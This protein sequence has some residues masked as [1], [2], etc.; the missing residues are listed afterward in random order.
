MRKKITADGGGL[1]FNS[2]KVRFDLLA[3]DA[4]KELAWVMTDACTRK[5]NPYPE[6]TEYSAFLW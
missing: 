4:M 5:E 2:G 6:I 3:P 1:R